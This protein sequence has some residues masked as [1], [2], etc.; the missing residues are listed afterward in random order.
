MGV[1]NS[2][3]PQHSGTSGVLNV[4]SSDKH[5]GMASLKG[6]MRRYYQS[7]LSR[8]TPSATGST[9]IPFNWFGSVPLG[10]EQIVESAILK[11]MLTEH[12]DK[13]CQL[14]LAIA[15]SKDL[16]RSSYIQK[17]LL[18]LLPKLAAFQREKFVS[19]FLKSTMTYMDRLLQGTYYNFEIIVIEAAQSRSMG[20]KL[21]NSFLLI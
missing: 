17:A 8:H 13:V 3:D 14:I 10:R 20:Q 16:A 6:A 4:L 12:Y 21:E 1:D 19:V 18:I 15:H 2:A 9:Q 11:Q 7:G 5:P